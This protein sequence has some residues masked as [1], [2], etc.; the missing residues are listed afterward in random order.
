MSVFPGGGEMGV[1]FFFVLGGFSMT[2]GY[3]NK[4]LQSNFCYCAYL[5]KR[6]IKFYPLHWLC[7]IAFL[8]IVYNTFSWFTFSLNAALLHSW[9]TEGRFFFSYNDVSWYLADTMFFAVI[10]PFLIRL[11]GR[12]SKQTKI[13]WGW[14]FFICY[15]LIY[16][17]VPNSY[18]HAI[19]YINPLVRLFDFIAGIYAALLF[20]ELRENKKVCSYVMNQWKLLSNSVFASLFLMLILSILMQ[21]YSLFLSAIYWPFIIAIIVLACLVSPTE[22]NKL[23]RNKVLVRFGEYSF[24]FYMLHKL[25]IIYIYKGVRPSLALFTDN[26]YFLQVIL[27]IICFGVTLLATIIVQKYYIKPLT[28]WLTKKIQPSMTARS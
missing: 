26:R 22:K 9:I 16:I 14:L 28:T 18:R 15:T 17:F 2:F 8:P 3:Y 20:Q 5:T 23:L 11:L 4:V 13:V 25:I 12:S 19:L 21:S 10:F 6:A 27:I 1:A 7:L 24:P